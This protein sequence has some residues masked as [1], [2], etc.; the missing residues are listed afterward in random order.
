MRCL[1]LAQAWQDAGGDSL[2]VL[3]TDLP[4]LEARLRS[5]GCEVLHLQVEPGS[6]TDALQTATLA[7]ELHAAWLVADGQHF[8]A[9]YQRAI[10]EAGLRLLAIDD[11]ANPEHC[12]ADVLLNQ[13]LHA[14]ESLHPPRIRPPHTPL[15]QDHWETCDAEH[16]TRHAACVEFGWWSSVVIR[17]DDTTA[18]VNPAC[19]ERTVRDPRAFSA[20]PVV[21]L[22]ATRLILVAVGIL[23]GLLVLEIGL[24]LFPPVSDRYFRTVGA[25][26]PIIY[27]PDSDPDLGYRIVPNMSYRYAD[28]SVRI[29]SLGLRD[30]ELGPADAGISRVLALG[31][32]ITFGWRVR[33]EESYPKL[34]E[35]LL[36]EIGESPARWEVINAGVGGYD[37]VQEL[38]YLKN[39]GLGFR[40]SV[41][42]LGFCVYNDLRGDRTA[43]VGPG[44]RFL[45]TLRTD[46]PSEKANATLKE[47]YQP[48]PTRPNS[49][50]HRSK[51]YS[52]VRR[53]LQNALLARMFS[54]EEHFLADGTGGG[55][56]VGS[57]KFPGNEADPIWIRVK[58]SLLELQQILLAR[59]IP[60]VIVLFP[61][62]S[63]IAFQ[64][65]TRKPQEILLRFLR[66]NGFIVVDLLPVYSTSGHSA[67]RLFVDPVHP[68]ALGHRLAACS[69]LTTLADSGTRKIDTSKLR[70]ESPRLCP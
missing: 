31:D 60:L 30:H 34:L 57:I 53:R 33:L 35:Q 63:Q 46:V 37:T 3:A 29:N 70:A 41:V 39:D 26:N 62:G 28:V 55:F 65:E 9:A 24:R 38:A 15:K 42:T 36:N 59:D 51:L 12:Y 61:T 43:V 4:V 44:G 52:F 13:N 1:S 21:K 56:Q 68:S 6:D 16:Q 14:D 10:K 40:P 25:G 50:L 2:F 5:E 66:A 67:D 69:I 64:E 20:N 54:L 23:A 49:L 48:E 27:R 47:L 18:S 45:S 7:H 8:G 19:D 11:G 17:R 32:S 22:L 58:T